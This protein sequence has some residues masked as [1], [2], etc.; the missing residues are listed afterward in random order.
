MENVIRRRSERNI[1]QRAYNVFLTL[2]RAA[3]EMLY[4]TRMMS[5]ACP[6]CASITGKSRAL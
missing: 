3:L 6:R 2:K 1:S 4:R 5:R